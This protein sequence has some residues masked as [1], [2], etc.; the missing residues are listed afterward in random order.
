MSTFLAPL[1]LGFAFNWASA[2]PS[3]LDSLMVPAARRHFS[4]SPAIQS[5][6]RV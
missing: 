6:W 2:L 5:G 1:L 3:P 4:H